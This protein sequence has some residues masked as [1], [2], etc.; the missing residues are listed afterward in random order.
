MA[1]IVNWQ[2][3]S[4]EVVFQ[5]YNRV[6]EK[7]VFKMPDGTE[8]DFYIKKE[9][10]AAAVLALTPDK[11]VILVKQYRPGPQKIILEL[12]GGYTNKNEDAQTAIERELL[13]ETGYRGNIQHVTDS[14]DCAYSTMIRSCFVATDCMRV[15]E[16]KLEAAE[17]AEV[18]LVPLNEFKNIVR[19]G[20]MTDV[21]VALLGL[22]FL[23]L[24]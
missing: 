21:E 17:F 24:L 10:P 13:E 18:T 2:E 14:L 7:V 1:S 20:Q 5:K 23:K 9:R 11:Q 3:L 22:D 8:K 12:P 4:R 16:Q 6:I 19:S 15:A